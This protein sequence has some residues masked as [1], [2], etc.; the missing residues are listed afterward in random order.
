MV[1]FGFLDVDVILNFRPQFPTNL[2]LGLQSASFFDTPQTTKDIVASICLLI[3]YVIISCHVFLWIMFSICGSI[4]TSLFFLKVFGGGWLL[5]PPALCLP[6]L[7]Q[8]IMI[9][10]LCSMFS[11]LWGAA[12][13][14]RQPYNC[15]RIVFFSTC[16]PFA[17][18]FFHARHTPYAT[19]SLAHMHSLLHVAPTIVLMIVVSLH[20]GL[21][22]DPKSSA[23]ESE[24]PIG[25]RIAV[26]RL[27]KT[28]T[29][30]LSMLVAKLEIVRGWCASLIGV[31]I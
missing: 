29:Q 15:I 24:W 5:H 26:S 2:L 25:A 7:T 30:C 12:T 9:E 16:L 13:I 8:P 17:R 19:H 14:S 1:T 27:S 18:R 20:Q 28:H 10:S 21:L 3:I 23:W 11:I 6:M 31:K 4:R 22:G